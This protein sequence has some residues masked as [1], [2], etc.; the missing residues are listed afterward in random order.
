MRV[1][2]K[3]VDEPANELPEKTVQLS[4][5]PVLGEYIRSGDEWYQVKR[6]VHRADAAE[7]AAE[8]Y[9]VSIADPTREP[10]RLSEWLEPAP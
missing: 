3:I 1:L 4:R 7:T 10:L 5:I 2:L 9:T 8:L 6:V